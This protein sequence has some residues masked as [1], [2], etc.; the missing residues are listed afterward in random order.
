[1][2]NQDIPDRRQ[3]LPQPLDQL[4]PEPAFRSIRSFLL[5]LLGAQEPSMAPRCPRKTGFP[6][7]PHCPLLER[8][9]AQCRPLRHTQAKP[10]STAPQEPLALLSSTPQPPAGRCPVS[11]GSS[12]LRLNRGQN[13][14][15]DPLWH[16][17][18][19]PAWTPCLHRSIPSFL[20]FCAFAFSAWNVPARNPLSCTS[21]IT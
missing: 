12:S 3:A 5:E 16:H 4:R 10:S 15:M 19:H 11:L 2:G 14:L 21:H 8:A 9:S 18:S 1:M 17:R 7:F 20:L 6:N 13:L